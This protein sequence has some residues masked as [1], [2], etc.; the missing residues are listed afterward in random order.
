LTGSGFIDMVQTMSAVL[1]LFMLDA[2][3]ELQQQNQ[4]F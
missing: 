4:I 1:L 3:M 2:F